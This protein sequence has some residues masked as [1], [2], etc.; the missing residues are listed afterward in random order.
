M[1]ICSTGFAALSSL[2]VSLQLSQISPEPLF[3]ESYFLRDAGWY[4]TGVYFTTYAMYASPYFGTR[5]DPA[6]LISYVTPYV[7]Q[8]FSLKLT[9]TGVT[10][11]LPPNIILALIAC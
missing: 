11:I 7:L 4:G 5:K 6:V 2:Y 8:F 1:A 10:F 3:L 9:C